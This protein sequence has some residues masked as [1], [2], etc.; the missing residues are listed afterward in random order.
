MWVVYVA[1]LFIGQM[2]GFD[3]FRWNNRVLLIAGE[4]KQAEQQLRKFLVL[5]EELSDRELLVFTPAPSGWICRNCED[6]TVVKDTEL[7]TN[8]SLSVWLIGKDGGIKLYKNEAV[9]PNQL[10][11]LIDSMPRRQTEMNRKE[12]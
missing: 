11:N 5:S 7:T 9:D 6:I 2:S 4:E 3:Q 8:A 1:A 10:F 12:N